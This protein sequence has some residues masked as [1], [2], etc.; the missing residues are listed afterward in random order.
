[1]AGLIIAGWDEKDGGSVYNVPVGGGLFKGPWAIGG[2]IHLTCSQMS[3]KSIAIHRI[4]KFLHLRLL[5][6]YFPRGL[7]KARNDRFRSKWFDSRVPSST[8]TY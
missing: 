3:F 6:F 7:F 2:E 1:M 5:R 8:I 4:W